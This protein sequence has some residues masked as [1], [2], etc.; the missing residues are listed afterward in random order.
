MHK[1][2]L[3]S[4]SLLNENHILTKKVILTRKTETKVNMGIF[5]T[6]PLSLG[7][8]VYYETTYIFENILGKILCGRIPYNVDKWRFSPAK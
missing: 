5:F 6:F 3:F 2:L 7:G 4:L 8:L 1:K